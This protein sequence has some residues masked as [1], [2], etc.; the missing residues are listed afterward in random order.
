MTWT[1]RKPMLMRICEEGG[2][3]RKRDSERETERSGNVF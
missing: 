2:K 1:M 3:E